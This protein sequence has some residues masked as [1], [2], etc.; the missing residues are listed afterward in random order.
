MKW[1]HPLSVMLMGAMVS[2]VIAAV[3]V[4]V[5]GEGRSGSASG[6]AVSTAGSAAPIDPLPTAQ[7]PEALPDLRVAT[8]AVIRSNFPDP[9][10]IK[11][12][13]TY[14]AY[15]TNVGGKN[16]PLAT[17]SA[18]EGPWTLLEPDGLPRLGS[19]AEAGSTWAPDVS[20][21]TDGRFLL[22]YTARSR[23][24]RMQ[25]IG[26]AVATVPTGPFTPVGAGPLICPTTYG[27]S[28]D[29]AS[30]VDT[31]GSRYVLYRSGLSP[32]K[33]STAAIYLQRVSGDGLT[34]RGAPVRILV[35]GPSDRILVE[36]PALVR[37]QNGY[38][39]LYSTDVFYSAGYRT[40]YATATTI[41]GPYRRGP[42]PLL[43]TQV[44]GKK[45]VGPGGADVL[46]DPTGDRIVFHGITEFL[47]RNTVIRAMYVTDLAWSNGLPAVRGATARYE[48][49]SGRLVRSQIRQD[50]SGASG[51][52]AVGYLDREG[53][54]VDIKVFAPAAGGYSLRI[55]HANRSPGDVRQ[56]LVVNGVPAMVVPYAKAD[57]GTWRRT[58]IGVTLAAGWNALGFQ[59]LTGSADLDYVELS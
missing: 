2:L 47:P 25:C 37:R 19:W 9:E 45:I 17:A 23:K 4:L 59:H 48:A 52:R 5:A 50:V 20:V 22:Y 7:G 11:V 31:D 35:Q 3:V 54:Q 57:G 12:G 6:P 46:H 10:M 58:T 38:A 34:L 8:E 15:A 53:S 55:G 43:S 26:A 39:L 28:I 13:N 18:P 49:E 1:R 33:R 56:T 21:R 24:A 51:G 16:L 27:D 41:T 30:F 40:N 42:K 14:Y 44:F 29:A 32:K 36:A